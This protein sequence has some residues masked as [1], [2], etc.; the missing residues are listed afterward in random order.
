[1]RPAALALSL[2]G[3]GIPQD[4]DLDTMDLFSH[5]FSPEE[6]ISN[7]QL[8]DLTVRELT[9]LKSVLLQEMAR[10]IVQQVSVRD[11]VRAR[12]QGVQA[13]LRSPRA[14]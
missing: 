5:F 2:S 13:Q 4:L 3:G 11:A 12:V 9:V 7:L 10:Q 14:Q 1:M 8:L 6:L